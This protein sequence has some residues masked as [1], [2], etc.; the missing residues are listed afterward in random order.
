M[1]IFRTKGASRV[2]IDGIDFVGGNISI[3]GTKVIVDGVEQDGELLGDVQI[4][5]HGDAQS[6]ETTKGNVSVQGKAT[7]VKTMS[8]DVTCGDVS[9][10]VGTMSGDVTCGSVGG[11]IKSMSGDIRLR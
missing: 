6:I 11:S 9:G 1:N 2:T 4:I 8:G 10:S 3:N 5:V 7:S